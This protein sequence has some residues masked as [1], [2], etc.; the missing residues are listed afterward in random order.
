VKRNQA[1]EVERITAI[2]IDF[3]ITDRANT[4]AAR[5]GKSQ[6]GEIA[7]YRG[8]VPRG[9]GFKP[10]TVA[11]RA[12]KLKPITNEHNW[13]RAIFRELEI[14]ERE[15]VMSWPLSRGAG[16]TMEQAGR[17]FYMNI[18]E[19]KQRREIACNQ[20]LL[21]SERMPFIRRKAA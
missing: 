8:D 5:A 17:A 6:Q 19:Y 3:L 12:E 4:E 1:Q 7:D 9:G 2:F 21:V 20:L 16:L 13:T 18:S 11:A 14:I 10:E 15:L